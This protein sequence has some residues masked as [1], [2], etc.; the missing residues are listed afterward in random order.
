MSES[1]P[2]LDTLEANKLLAFLQTQYNN[3]SEPR[4][5]NRNLLMGLL[6]YDAGL[7][8][9]EVVQ[10]VVGDLW[11]QDEP[12]QSLL[13]RPEVAK[14]GRERT[15]P[16]TQ[17][18]T[19][20]IDQMTKTWWSL[21]GCFGDEYA[22]YTERPR[23]HI[24]ARQVERIIEHAGQEAIGKD[25]NPHM[26]RH[27]FASRLMRTTSMRVVQQLLGH[28]NIATTQIYTHPNSDDLNNAIRTI[29]QN[30]E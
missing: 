10:L 4:R 25:V 26:L 16:L 6:M 9:G 12:R 30:Q 19:I 13:V 8:V 24:S 27:S 18:I 11:F 15:V 21:T 5:S 17:R 7:R 20:V 14:G 1:P 29:D 3:T 2:T 28:K 22:F 23:T